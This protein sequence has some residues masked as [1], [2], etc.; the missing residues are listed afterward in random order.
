MVGHV[1]IIEPRSGQITWDGEPILQEFPSDW[2]V[3]DLVTARYHEM[4]Q[5]IDKAQP[6]RPIHG[7]D[8]ELPSVVKITV[9][10]WSKHLDLIIYMR[11]QTA[12]K[13]AI[14]GITTEMP[15]MTRR[16]S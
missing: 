1:L 2:S 5:P 4:E 15:L 8:L 3:K 9:N 16:T 10:R 13:T 14:A 11:P 12:G 7:I 6:F